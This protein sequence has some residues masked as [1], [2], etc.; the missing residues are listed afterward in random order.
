MKLT[1]LRQLVREE[2]TNIL[3]ESNIMVFSVS[4]KIDSLT[5]IDRQKLKHYR[6]K[7]INFARSKDYLVNTDQT[8]YFPNFSWSGNIYG[9]SIGML[10]GS[11]TISIHPINTTK[12]FQIKEALLARSIKNGKCE[13]YSLKNL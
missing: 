8:L 4:S 7:S 13:S 3:A 6:D 10:V 12:M 5:G 9:P 2:L 11:D 1:Q